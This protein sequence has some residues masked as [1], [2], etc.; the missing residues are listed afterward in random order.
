MSPLITTLENGL[1]IITDPMPHLETASVGVWVGAGARNETEGTNGIAHMLEHMAFKGTQRRTARGIAEEIE[2]VGGFINAYTGREQTAYYARVLRDD[3][4]LAVDIIA[5]I[6]QNSTFDNEEFEREKGVVIQ[7]IGQAEDTP[8]DVIFDHLQ[9]QAFPAQPLGRPILGSEERVRGFT[10]DDLIMQ[11]STFYRAPSML[12]VSAG[13]VQHEDMVRLARQHLGALPPGMPAAPGGAAYAGG[14]YREDG[15]LEQAHLALAFKGVHAREDE[16]Y[17]MQVYSTV[18]GGGMSSRLFQE[19]REKRGLCYSIH[20]FG[21]SY[22]DTGLFGVYAGTS[23]ADAQE[24]VHV[25]A[26]EMKALADNVD[27]DELVRAKAQIRSGLL[28]G[29]EQA[30]ARCEQIAGQYLTF[31]RLFTPRELIARIDAVDA[32]AVRSMAARILSSGPKSLAVLGP[33]SQLGSYDKIA[34]RFA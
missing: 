25:I 30:S 11:V 13:A 16:V 14:E 21:A 34:G 20:A 28:M 8:D 3:V 1:T 33:A 6:L 19:A 32:A 18:L 12:L 5:D 27:D 10:R 15:D 31:G 2:R 24:L 7:E 9:L 17:D 29:L 22:A 4:P 26:G 23:G